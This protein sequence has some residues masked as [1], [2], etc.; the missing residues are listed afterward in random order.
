ML[1]GAQVGLESPWRGILTQPA[2]WTVPAAFAVMVAVSLA[3]P[4]RQNPGTARFMSKLHVPE[5]LH[6]VPGQVR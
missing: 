5:R 1:L 6:A 2:A 4:G 3:T